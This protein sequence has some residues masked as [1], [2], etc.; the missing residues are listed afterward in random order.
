MGK[1]KDFF[2]TLGKK[3]F[4]EFV[5][6][7]IRHPIREIGKLNEEI[8]RLKGEIAISDEDLR[9]IEQELSAWYNKGE[10]D[11]EYSEF[12]NEDGTW[13]KDMDHSDRMGT[14]Y[15]EDMS[16]TQPSMGFKGNIDE[17]YLSPDDDDISDWR[18]ISKSFNLDTGEISHILNGVKF[19][20]KSLKFTNEH[21]NVNGKDIAIVNISV[22]GELSMGSDGN[23][24]LNG[25]PLEMNQNV[26]NRL[27]EQIK[28]LN[29]QNA[30]L[31]FD[32]GEFS[33]LPRVQDKDSEEVVAE[34][35]PRDIKKELALPPDE[36]YRLAM[37]GK[38]T[39]NRIEEEN[40]NLSPENVK[41]GKLI[42]EI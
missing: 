18:G 26:K 25:Q 13:N 15:T 9:R 21:K 27:A 36:Q 38:E 17:R 40:K 1:I 35:E 11:F 30:R 20:E 3:D 6:K 42:E 37:L 7:Y 33:I 29:G 10:N 39:A 16:K 23:I 19:P 34:N 22:N 32:N 12:R 24:L 4:W 31:S 2:K 41:T 14:G 8:K 28:G 5:W